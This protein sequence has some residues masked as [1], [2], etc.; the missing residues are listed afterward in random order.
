MPKIS[1]TFPTK[2]DI[3]IPTFQD[4][5]SVNKEDIFSLVSS[6]VIGYPIYVKS[7]KNNIEEMSDLTNLTLKFV[8]R[9]ITSFE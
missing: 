6:L 5:K 8:E 2:E 4:I 9:Y 7:I 1:A 3:K